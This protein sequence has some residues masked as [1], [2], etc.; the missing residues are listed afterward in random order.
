VQLALRVADLDA[1]I[2]F[3]SKLFGAEPA[4]RRPG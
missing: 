3:Y 2:E 4:K 1:S